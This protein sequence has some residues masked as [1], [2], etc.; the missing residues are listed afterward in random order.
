[1]RFALVSAAA[2]FASGVSGVVSPDSVGEAL[3]LSPTS[4]RGKAEIRAGLGGTYAALGGWAL[5]NR[6]PAASSAVGY[7]WLGAA[8]VR[9]ASLKLD[10][11]RTDLAF[12][13]YLATE[14]SLGTTAVV[15]AR[16]AVT[17]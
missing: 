3:A 4:G 11:P 6:S 2:L 14:L 9:I 15:E 7:T 13:L 10:R 17:R 12:W 8:V 16:K 1:V 5:V